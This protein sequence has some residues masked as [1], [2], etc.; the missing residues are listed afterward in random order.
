MPQVLCIRPLPV[1]VAAILSHP[2]AFPARDPCGHAVQQRDRAS[3]GGFWFSVKTTGVYCLPSWAARPPL[4]KNV[5]FHASPEAAEAA[6]FRPCKRCKPR[7]WQAEVGL[8]RL[9]ARARSWFD[10]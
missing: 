6:G 1:M 4:R 7:D 9:V 8:S 2:G 5:A 3:N 10:A